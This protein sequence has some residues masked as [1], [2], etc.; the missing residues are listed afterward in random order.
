MIFFTM[1]GV[2]ALIINVLGWAGILTTT[3]INFFPWL[4]FMLFPLVIPIFTINQARTIYKSSP[5]LQQGV[6]YTFSE[7]GIHVKSVD[8]EGSYDWQDFMRVEDLGKFLLLSPAPNMAEI[9]KKALFTDEQ[10]AF[11]K[12]S[13]HA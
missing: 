4:I 2:V 9:L 13:V 10:L 1:L 12:K 8:N 5:R 3:S 7:Q 6:T 11:I